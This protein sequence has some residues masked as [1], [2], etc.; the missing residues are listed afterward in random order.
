M[1]PKVKRNLNV[2]L[3]CSKI[4]TNNATLNASMNNIYKTYTSTHQSISGIRHHQIL[5]NSPILEQNIVVNVCT[6]YKRE[7]GLQKAI[8]REVGKEG[9]VV[10][11]KRYANHARSLN[12]P[13]NPKSTRSG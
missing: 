4:K 10:D 12:K 3:T 13:Y 1:Q 7:G 5:T 8:R 2:L 6:E 9:E 11:H